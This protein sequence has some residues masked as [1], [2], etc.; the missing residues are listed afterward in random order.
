MNA[1]YVVGDAVGETMFYGAGAGS[2]PTASAVVGDVLALADAICHSDRPQAEIEPYRSVLP[3]RPVDD[4]VTRYYIRL[5]V[6]DEVGALAPVVGV[7]ARNGIS[8]SQINQLQDGDGTRCSVVFLTHEASERD[9]RTARAELAAL[10]GVERV[11]SVIRIEDVAAW[12]DGAE[13]NG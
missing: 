13:A 3:L 9:V 5:T 1:V 11:A 8:I 10:P 4:L 6:A 2:F 12:T 7:F